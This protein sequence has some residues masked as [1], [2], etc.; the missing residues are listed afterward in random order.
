[1]LV[2][3]KNGSKRKVQSLA[4]RPNPQRWWALAVLSLVQ[5][6]L[7]LDATVVNVALPS[8]KRDLGM[9]AAGLAWVSTATC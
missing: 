4:E 5:F 8:L 7:V 1:M 2:I 9:G 3:G 6:M